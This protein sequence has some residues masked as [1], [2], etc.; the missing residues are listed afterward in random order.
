MGYEIFSRPRTPIG[1][2]G[3]EAR[4]SLSIF[5]FQL[6]DALFIA[7]A[8][9]NWIS[10]FWDI[11]LRQDST[12]LALYILA[13]ARCKRIFHIFFCKV[14]VDIKAVIMI[15]DDFDFGGVDIIFC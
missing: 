2:S 1:S 3:S 11:D 10:L 7:F 14:G 5:G 4:S 8:S 12:L 13:C 6:V 9:I 15:D